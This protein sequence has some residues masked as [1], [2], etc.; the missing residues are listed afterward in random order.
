M[1]LEF[2]VSR[3]VQESTSIQSEEDEE[4]HSSEEV[5]QEQPQ[6]SVTTGRQRSE[7]KP[8]KK[9]SSYA[10]LVAFAL[11]IV[12]EDVECR[13]LYTYHKAVTSSESTHWVIAM[14]KEL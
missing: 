5:V 3:N 10:E 9:Y 11:N 1:E 13:E 6:Y 2:D 8:P 4:Q 12:E 14:N 7:I